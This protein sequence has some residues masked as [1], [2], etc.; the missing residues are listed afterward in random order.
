MMNNMGDPRTLVL[1]RISY[2]GNMQIDNS[3]PDTIYLDVVGSNA[4][5]TIYDAT[6]PGQFIVKMSLIGSYDE[7]TQ[8]IALKQVVHLPIIPLIFNGVVFSMPNSPRISIFGTV[9]RGFLVE[10]LKDGKLV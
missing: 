2:M 4:R 3:R 9:K 7:N 8:G 6:K 5:A 1:P 10:M